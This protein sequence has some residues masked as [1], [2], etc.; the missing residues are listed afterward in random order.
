MIHLPVKY[1]VLP[2]YPNEGVIDRACDFEYYTTTE[3]NNLSQKK[4]Y[5]FPFFLL[6]SLRF[7]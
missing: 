7:R 1:P 5:S 2:K 6:H 4:V 3:I